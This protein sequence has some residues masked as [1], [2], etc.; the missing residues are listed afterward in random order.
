MINTRQLGVVGETGIFCRSVVLPYPPPAQYLATVT[1][2]SLSTCCIC[3]A[4]SY[5]SSSSGCQ[6]G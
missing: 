2:V 3:G 6:L 1:F 4:H 5:S